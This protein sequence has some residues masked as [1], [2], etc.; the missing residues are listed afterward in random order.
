VP[1]SKG[2][3][4]K[5][6]VVSNIEVFSGFADTRS[7]RAWF[8]NFTDEKVELIEDFSL[9]NFRGASNALCF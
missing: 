5:V 9:G 7:S 3:F 4:K 8:L 1:R 2:R 6:Y